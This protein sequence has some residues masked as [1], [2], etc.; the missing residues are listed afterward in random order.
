MLQEPMKQDGALLKALIERSIKQY[1]EKL[2]IIS[3]SRQQSV[4]LLMYEDK[5]NITCTQKIIAPKGV[6]VESLNKKSNS[7]KG[8]LDVKREGCHF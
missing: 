3:I 6:Y 2:V 1:W 5:I 8:F 7:F 4:H